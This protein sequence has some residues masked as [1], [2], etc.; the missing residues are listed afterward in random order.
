MKLVAVVVLFEPEK[1]GIE[2]IR[3]NIESYS[4]FVDRIFLID[5]SLENNAEF[6][7]D[8]KKSE[9]MQNKNKGGIAGAQ[10]MGCSRALEEGCEWVLTMDQDSYFEEVQL[11]NYISQ[12]ED[13]IS[14]DV[15][16]VSFGPFIKDLNESNY[17]TVL[18][19]RNV[20]SPLKKKILGK[21]YKSV[22]DTKVQYVTEVIASGNIVKL[23]AWNQIKYDEFLFIEQVDY[24]FCHNIIKKG[25]RIAKLMNVYLD[26]HFGTRQ[27]ALLKKNYP[28]YGPFRIY[29][30]FRNLWVERHRFPEYHE[31]YTDIL[32]KRLFDCCVNTIHPIR[33][34]KIILKAYRD[35]KEYLK[36]ERSI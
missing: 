25:Y 29:Y 1:I 34:S 32:R 35:Y 4:D 14:K 13:I 6:F 20:L 30:I 12:V 31:K 19:R 16:V 22:F 5:N 7:S 26:Q 21:R 24:D 2:K 36:N 28:N 18:L 15:S 10:N 27:F 33:N 9:Y 17:W 23:E 3:S 8:I 11:Q